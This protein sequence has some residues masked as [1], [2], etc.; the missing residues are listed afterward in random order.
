MRDS[1]HPRIL[2]S[3]ILTVLI[4]AFSSVSTAQPFPVTAKIPAFPGA[5]GFGRYAEGGRGGDVYHVTNLDDAGPGSLRQG[6][7]TAKGPRTIVFDVA[8]TITLKSELS[9]EQKSHLSIAGQTSPGKGITLRDRPF[10]IKK[11]EH[12]TVRYLRIRLGDENKRKGE[13]PDVMTVDYNNHINSR[14]ISL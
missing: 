6:I 2:Q 14:S 3:L 9:I 7:Q 5:E 11:S 10:T 8:G 13:S 4:S 12:I 1:L